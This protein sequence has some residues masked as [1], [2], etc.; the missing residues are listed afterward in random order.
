MMLHTKYENMHIST[1]VLHLCFKEELIKNTCLC[2]YQYMKF[3]SKKNHNV[4]PVVKVSIELY[5]HK[6]AWITN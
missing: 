6:L 2:C 4:T 5:S 1:S 3:Q